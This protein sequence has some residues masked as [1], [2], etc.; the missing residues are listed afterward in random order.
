MDLRSDYRLWSL[1]WTQRTITRTG[2]SILPG[3]RLIQWFFLAWHTI[4]KISKKSV[5][6][7]TFHAKLKISV[8]FCSRLK[9]KC[10]IQCDKKKREKRKAR[11]SKQ[12]LIVRKICVNNKVMW[13]FHDDSDD[14]FHKVFHIKWRFDWK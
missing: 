3:I 10:V 14:P 11:Q 12:R 7:W 13:H 5:W 4:L 8:L 1:P 9:I 6:N 2:R